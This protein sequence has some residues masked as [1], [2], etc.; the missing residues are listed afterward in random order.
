MRVLVVE[1]DSVTSKLNLVGVI[2]TGSRVEMIS[3]PVVLMDL[4]MGSIE[5]R[6]MRPRE[7]EKESKRKERTESNDCG[8]ANGLLVILSEVLSEFLSESTKE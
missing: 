5:L 2:H 3:S 6:M 4:R 8:S 7:S 1:I